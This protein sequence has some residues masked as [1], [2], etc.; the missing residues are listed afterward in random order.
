MKELKE[1]FQS[2]IL[3][4]SSQHDDE[5]TFHERD[6]ILLEPF[7][8]NLTDGVHRPFLIL[9]DKTHVHTLPVA[10]N[11]LEAGI[12]LSQLNKS[13]P[14]GSPHTFLQQFLAASHV[15]VLRAVFVQ[16]KGTH[17]FVRIYV[18]GLPGVSSLRVRADEA[19]SLCVYLK[20]PIFAT[21]DFI[22]RSKVMSFETEKG[23]KMMSVVPEFSR[24][25]SYYLN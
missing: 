16:I 13:I 2:Q 9:K 19:M 15:E 4:Y 12:I 7:G 14:E 21:L 17:Q 25:T 10:I 22:S 5:E 11:P 23:M 1:N 8:I 24:K 6:L 20:I 3:L 18:Q